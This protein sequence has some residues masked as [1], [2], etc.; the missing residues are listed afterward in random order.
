MPH[1]V[2]CA[3]VY[4]FAPRRVGALELESSGSSHLVAGSGQGLPPAPDVGGVE[5]LPLLPAPL[6]LG[7]PDLPPGRRLLGPL[8]QVAHPG[9]QT[10]GLTADE[11][12]GEEPPVLAEHL[13][14]PVL[15]MVWC[16]FPDWL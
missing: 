9:D 7:G 11:E 16:I 8:P 12:T 4:V 2:Q 6:L 10:G 5:G 13:A 15:P 1:L 14:G 3:N